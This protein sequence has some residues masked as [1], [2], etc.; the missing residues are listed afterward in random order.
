PICPRPAVRAAGRWR[1]SGGPCRTRRKKGPPTA[2]IGC[3]CGCGLGIVGL[4]SP[5]VGPP[6]WRA[7]SGG[8]SACWPPSVQDCSALDLTS[9]SIPVIWLKANVE[10]AIHTGTACG[11]APTSAAT[12]APAQIET[13]HWQLIRYT[14]FRWK[15][16]S[17]SEEH[18]SEL[19]SREN[20][21]CRLLLEQKNLP[22]D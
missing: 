15:A 7:F 18:T 9:T 19:Q 14:S 11:N 2:C 13:H 1:G 10:S 20:L 6:A 21:V 8:A 16:F 5:E 3:R 22:R 12:A 4:R 17:R